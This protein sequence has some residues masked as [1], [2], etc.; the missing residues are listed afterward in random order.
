[1]ITNTAEFTVAESSRK[2]G[3]SLDWIYRLIRSGRMSCRKSGGIWLIPQ[4]E[5]DLRLAQRALRNGA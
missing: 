4:T 2:L 3:V 5:I 1:M